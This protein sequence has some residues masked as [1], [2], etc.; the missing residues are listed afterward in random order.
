MR[1]FGSIAALAALA[2]VLSTATP[3]AQSTQAASLFN[4]ATARE[5]DLRKEIAASPASSQDIADLVTRM[6]TLAHT[7]E[8]LWRLFPTSPYSDDA[9]WHGGMLAGD[10]FRQT[11]DAAD[12]TLALRMF[13]ALSS[14][15]PTSSLVKRV[16]AEVARLESAKAV[17]TTVTRTATP[18]APAPATPIPAVTTTPAGPRPATTPVTPP[19]T[20]PATASATTESSAVSTLTAIRREVLPDVLRVTLELEREP[21]FNAEE[22]DGPR[23]VFIDMENTRA[24]ESMRDARLAV[25]SDVVQ[26]IR[27]G[28]QLNGRIR[29][30]FDLTGAG[31]YSVYTL[32]NP[33]RIV[34]DFER[35]QPAARPAVQQA[36]NQPAAPAAPRPSPTAATAPP[37]ARPLSGPPGAAGPSTNSGSS[38]AESRDD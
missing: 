31:K 1:S 6:R 20:R 36:G 11:G 37:V 18:P 12:R 34:V 2:V 3:R 16:P 19:A 25:N 33:F 35:R 30:V 24:A 10:T 9:L 26:Q 32:Y 8:D 23:R 28:R 15:F 14:K 29:V 21:V 38:R 17:E 13:R 5:A 27:V 22:I 4:Q 7:Y